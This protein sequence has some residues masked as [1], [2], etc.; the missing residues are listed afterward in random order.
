MSFKVE[1]LSFKVEISS[2]QSR[3]LEFQSR[4]LEFQ[5]RDLE[6]QSRDLEFNVGHKFSN[7]ASYYL[8]FSSQDLEFNSRDLE[9]KD[10]YGMALIELRTKQDDAV[11]IIEIFQYWNN[12]FLKSCSIAFSLFDCLHSNIVAVFV[13]DKSHRLV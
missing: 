3:D 2:F 1:I 8:E 6:F 13:S 10:Y 4:D 7:R 11:N 12:I 5:S 9:F